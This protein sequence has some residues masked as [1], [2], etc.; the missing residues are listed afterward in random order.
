M[1]VNYADIREENIRRY[2]TDV[3]LYGKKLL[4]ERYDER[5]HFL[6]ELLQN[7]E[8]ALRRLGTRNNGAVHFELSRTCLR[9]RHY[10]RQ[11]NESDVRGI[12]GIATGTKETDEGTIGR[13]GIGFKAVYAFTDK[14]CVWSG[15]EAFA[16]DSYVLPEAIPG[17]DLPPGQTV[18]ELPFRTD[19][20]TAFE[21]VH[22][23]LKQL[24]A[25]T[26]LFLDFIDEI[27]WSVEGGDSGTYLRVDLGAA[28]ELGRWIQLLGKSASTEVDETWLVMREPGAAC[29]NLTNVG[30]AFQ[31]TPDKDGRQQVQAVTDATLVVFFPTVRATG[32]GFFIHGPYRTT[33]SRD[34]VLTSDPLN[35]DLL[36]RTADSLKAWLAELRHLGLWNV[37]A[38]RVLPLDAA[39]F[40]EGNFFAPLFHA[41]REAV[42]T[43]PFVPVEDREFAPGAKVRIARGQ[44][45]RLLLGSRE[46]AALFGDL[47]IRWVSAELTPDREPLVHRYMTEVLNVP[48]ITPESF[49]RQLTAEFLKPRTDAWMQCLYEYLNNQPSVTR[50]SYFLDRPVLRLSDNTHVTPTRDKA[51]LPTEEGSGFPTIKHNVCAS[52]E[53]IAFLERLGLR[54]PDLVDDL[55]ANVLPKYQSDSISVSDDEYAI[56]VERLVRAWKTDST[57]Q[58]DKLRV[59]LQRSNIVMATECSDGQGYVHRPQ[60][61]YIASQRMREMFAGVQDV[62][63]VDDA[64]DCL[65]GEAARDLLVGAG[66]SRTLR[67]VQYQDEFSEEQKRQ[68]RLDAGQVDIT[69]PVSLQDYNI[70]GLESLLDLL[71]ELPFDEAAARAKMLWDEL[72]DLVDYRGSSALFGTYQWTFYKRRSHQFSAKFVRILNERVWIP[73]SGGRLVKPGE[74]E[75][76]QLTSNWRPNPA[77]LARIRFKPASIKVLAMELGFEPGVLDILKR[78][79]LTNEASLRAALDRLGLDSDTM[80]ASGDEESDDES[81][82]SSSQ[83]ENKPRSAESGDEV[84]PTDEPQGER[85]GWHGSW[86]G[87]TGDKAGGSGGGV[88]GQGSGRSSGGRNNGLAAQKHGSRTFVSYV[89]V[90]ADEDDFDDSGS[91]NNEEQLKLERE[92]IALILFQEPSLS[93]TPTNNPGFDLQ[94]VTDEGRIIRRVEVKAMAGCLA[95]RPVALSNTQFRTAMTYGDSFWLYVVEHARNPGMQNIVRIQDPARQAKYFS[96]DRGWAE[97]SV[98]L[99]EVAAQTSASEFDG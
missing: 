60:Q 50:S 78:V 35:Q 88:T 61:V 8:D 79:G 30:A 85:S 16:I 7:A 36:A 17:I 52:A 94:E 91:Q 44:D 92:A 81:T 64:Y 28:G 38:M 98:P 93:T 14:P 51:Y 1:A 62:Y 2:G 54:K 9:L 48:V 3:V 18:I 66:A 49:I 37:Q 42:G 74:V 63:L 75:F 19:L 13:F 6:L 4:V 90:G 89:A 26:L 27:N 82:D 72:C 73:A 29:S 77:L 46:S 84:D 99:E 80:T 34:N 53:A 40:P 83:E 33:P 25:R 65:K 47:E 12:C 68:M 23:G 86:N 69:S 59:A 57:S 10:G 97:V 11:F 20:P 67:L 95:D 5:L 39:R 76:E 87:S 21:E 24:G 56:D 15:D 31:V 22:R 58:R 55:V 70:D 41:A 96:F 32:L 71:E 45:L 43:L